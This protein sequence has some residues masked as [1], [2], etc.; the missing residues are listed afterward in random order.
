MSGYLVGKDEDTGREDSSF[1]Q[2]I[3][4]EKEPSATKCHTAKPHCAA[5]HEGLTSFRLRC[6]AAF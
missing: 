5:S 2:N 1:E 6:Q 3:G 4:A